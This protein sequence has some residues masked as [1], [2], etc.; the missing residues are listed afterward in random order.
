MPRIKW[1][2]AIG[3]LVVAGVAAWALLVPVCT[4]HNPLGM[5]YLTYDSKWSVTLYSKKCVR[6]LPGAT[7]HEYFVLAVRPMDEPAPQSE[8]YRDSEVVFEVESGA[9]PPQ[10]LLTN[11]QAMGQFSGLP[12]DERQHSFLVMCYPNCPA[13]MVRKQVN[14]YRDVRVHYFLQD[15]LSDQPTIR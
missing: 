12:E 3:G 8:S 2:V 10:V 5:S 11:P 15:R 14:V 13:A 1:I 6:R 4:I 9:V 7:A